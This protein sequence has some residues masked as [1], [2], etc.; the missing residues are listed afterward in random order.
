MMPQPVQTIREPKDGT[1]TSSD[2]ADER[3]QDHQPASGCPDN[4]RLVLD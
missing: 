1:G 3:S 4:G 2:H